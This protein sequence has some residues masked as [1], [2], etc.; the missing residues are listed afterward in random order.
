[1]CGICGIV[2]IDSQSVDLALLKDM[3]NLMHHRGPDD[4]GTYNNKYIGMGTR[5]LSV[6]DLSTGH[7]PISNEDESIWVIQNG[8]IYNY[9]ELRR[10]S[11][12]KGHVYKTN[13]DT[14]VIVHLYEEYGEDFVKKL[15]GMFSLAIWDE[16]L[17]KLILARDRIGI[18]PLF[19]FFDGHKFVFASEIKAILR[20]RSIKREIDMEAFNYYL[21]YKFVPA[22]LSMFN[23]IAKLL[24]GHMLVLERGKIKINQYWDFEYD[25]TSESR[26]T[27][28][29]RFHEVLR[30]SIQRQL[31]SDVPLGVFL[32][33]GIDSSVL[34]VIMSELV[35][36][37]IKTFS[38]T[39][40]DEYCDESRYVRMVADQFRTDH[41]ELIVKPDAIDI[42]PKLIW[43]L[44][45]PLGD[46]CVLPMYYLSKF[47]REYVT[48]ALSGDGGDELFAGYD[49]YRREKFISIFCRIPKWI[50]RSILGPATIFPQLERKAK[51]IDKSLALSLEKRYKF[52]MEN[53]S[54]ET[55]YGLIN[56]NSSNIDSSDIVLNHFKECD[57]T[58]NLK[59][60]LYV[61]LKSYLPDDLLFKVDRMSMANSLEVRVPFLDEKVVEFSA[62]LPTKLKLKGFATTKTK[63]LLRKYLRKHLP[64]DIHKRK[65]Q[66]FNLPVDSWFRGELK[67]FAYEV[68]LDSGTNRSGIF[69]TNGLELF[70]KQ[71]QDGENH[72]EAIWALIAFE[73][74]RRQY[75]DA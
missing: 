15:N 36:A 44:D 55:K 31:I 21:S 62:S 58:E 52:W 10:E 9:R 74:W 68:L 57:V 13:S 72:G 60:M 66:G 29:E 7:M 28:L 42:L 27:Y 56:N 61:D 18:K 3:I 53:I 26:N 38:V 24:P 35:D 19:Y 37:P 40:E 39:F 6:I 30:E 47:T 65:K 46:S 12:S 20:D 32:S 69:N 71:H 64:A 70:L 16:K 2:N 63:Y 8:E 4:E 49:R 51:L 34:L 1:M 54:E 11:E 5:R 67:S 41:H 23:D 73:L 17:E 22:P 75:I 59:K 33:G 43:H 45:E 25:E 14:E 48:V 50:Q